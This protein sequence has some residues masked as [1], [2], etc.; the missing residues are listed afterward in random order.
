MVNGC[1]SPR[2]GAAFFIPGNSI[3][4]NFK[5]RGRPQTGNYFLTCLKTKRMKLPLFLI[6]CLLGGH[7]WSQ[8]LTNYREFLFVN[9]NNLALAAYQVPGA[10]QPVKNN[11]EA[12]PPDK[13]MTIPQY[14]TDSVYLEPLCFSD[15]SQVWIVEEKPGLCSGT[16]YRTIR[17]KATG[18]YLTV[19][20]YDEK[21]VNLNN[22]RQTGYRLV[23]QE[24]RPKGTDIISNQKWRFANQDDAFA[25]NGMQN[26]VYREI[27]PGR[28][29]Y[30][31]LKNFYI[32]NCNV[33]SFSFDPVY[34]WS[35]NK[36][37]VIPQLLTGGYSANYQRGK[38]RVIPA[39]PVSFIRL[40]DITN[41]RCP[42]QLLSGDR[43]FN[44]NIA[45]ELHARLELSPDRTRIIFSCSFK[46]REPRPDYTSTEISWQE[47]VYSAPPGGKIRSIVS[48]TDFDHLF[49]ANLNKGSFDVI[50]CEMLRYCEVVGDTMGD[51]ISKDNNC[52]DDTRLGN[53]IFNPLAVILE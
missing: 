28:T 48:R 18:K 3:L 21:D 40:K 6:S 17:N 29:Q 12:M 7:C 10:K 20:G 38:F 14:G 13:G 31:C 26:S 32:D 53:F 23:L 4:S 2:K 51:D 37:S 9:D 41:F 16:G 11:N 45:M 33:S 1:G 50:Q 25:D 52:E 42:T 43:D 27:F 5:N 39:R 35:G 49:S 22:L 34:E 46:A 44:G 30:M 8:L 15:N 36:M 47:T 19:L 24:L